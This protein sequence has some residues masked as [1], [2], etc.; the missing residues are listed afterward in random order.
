MHTRG[1]IVVVPIGTSKFTSSPSHLS[2]LAIPLDNQRLLFPACPAEVFKSIKMSMSDRKAELER[3]KARLQALR[4][5]KEKRRKE[6]EKKEVQSA[7]P[8]VSS[9]AREKKLSNAVLIVIYC[10]YLCVGCHCSDIFIV[11]CASKLRGRHMTERVCERSQTSTMISRSSFRLNNGSSRQCYRSLLFISQQFPLWVLRLPRG[12][13]VNL[14][15][16]CSWRG[17]L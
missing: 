4:D 14:R 9:Y 2:Y 6:K 11:M 10:K 5:E 3:K 7:F 17:R 8:C 13:C 16:L 1:M 12:C 15:W